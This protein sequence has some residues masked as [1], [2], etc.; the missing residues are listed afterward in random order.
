[1]YNKLNLL[2]KKQNIMQ[3]FLRTLTLL[4]CLAMP[5][6]AQAQNVLSFD[7]EDGN[8]PAGWTNDA[9]YPWEVVS[10]SQGSG[11]AGTYC[12]KSGN[13]GVGSSTSTLSATF[14]FTTAGSIS[15][16][17]G[18]YGE[19]TSTVWDKCIFTIDGVQQFQYG[20]LAAWDTYS[21][22]VS[23]GEHTF[24]WS[25]SKD[26]SVNPTG[27]AFFVDNVVVELSVTCPKPSNLAISDLTAHTATASWTAGGSE[28]SWGVYVN[29]TYMGTVN[30]PSYAIT[31]LDANTDCSFAVTSICG[32]EDASA[33]LSISFHTPCESEVLP[34][35]EAFDANLSSNI[36][37]GYASGITAADVF[38]GTPLTIN[39]GGPSSGW[40]YQSA[41]SNG[42]PA[43]HYRVNIYG[44]SC[45][46]WMVTPNIDLTSATSA[47]LTFDAA[48]TVY[49]SGSSAPA[50]GF[51]NNS[52]QAFMVLISTDGG[53]TWLESNATKWQ[54]EGGNY[55]LASLASSDYI[56][57]TVNLNQ[58]LGQN[59]RIAFYAQS[60]TS[61]GDNNLHIDNI[62]IDVIPTCLKVTNL[63]V[64]NV[65]NNTVTLTWTDAINTGATY[66]VYNGE[67]LVANGIAATT[68]TVTGLT[69]NTPYTF[70][71]VANCA[72]DD[73][74]RPVSVST[75][76]EC[77]PFIT[78]PYSNDLEGEPYYSVVSYAEAFPNC[79][80]RFND[81]STASNGYYPRLLSSSS[82]S[83]SGSVYMQLYST[84]TA[85]YAN[86]QMA[87]LPAVD[88]TVYPMNNNMV[89]F[90]ARSSNSTARTVIVGT[91]SDPTDL[92]TFT[93]V[94][95]VT[96]PGS[97]YEFFRVKLTSSPANN[98]YVAI[99]FDRNGSAT[100]YVDDIALEE[101]PS[102][103]VVENLNVTGVTN[104]SIS[105]S[106]SANAE[107]TGDVTYIVM[108]GE[109]VVAS[110]L[111]TTEYTVTGLAGSTEY[112]LSVLSSC[113]A[114]DNA[115]P[116]SVTVRTLC[117]AQSLPY[118][119]TFE[120]DDETIVCYT[121]SG[122]NMWSV[123]TGD[124]STETGAHSGTYN[125][126]IIHSNNGDATKLIS[127][128]LDLTSVESAM[129]KFWHI[130]RAW[131][132]DQ[133]ELRVYYRTNADADWTLIP[134]AE[135]TEEVA[136]WTEARFVLPNPTATYQI[137]FEMTD[138][139]GYGVAIDD[140]E[141][142]ETP[143]H[144][145]ALSYLTTEDGV[146][147]GSA[148]ADNAN[149]YWGNTV[150]LT[151]TPAT[152][153]RTAAWYAGNLTSVEGETPLAIDEDE[154]EFVITSDTA[155]TVV[156]GYGQFEIKGITANANQ[157]RMGSVAGNS[158]YDNDMYDYA[159][160]ATLTATANTGFQFIEWR[161]E[162]GSV[163]ST[164]N[165]I[166]I[167]AYQPLTLIAH[168]G[169]ATYTV[170]FE[171]EHGTVEGVG[172]YTFGSMAT[173]TAV[174]DEHY[175]FVRWAD[176]E[177][178]P[179][180]TRNI[181]V[182]SDITVL[183]I[184]EPDVYTVTVNGPVQVATYT[185][186]NA[187]G[188]ATN[189][190]EYLTEATVAATNIDDEHYTFVGWS[191]RHQLSERVYFL[192]RT[193]DDVTVMLTFDEND[194]VIL[195]DNYG[196]NGEHVNATT[197]T[198]DEINALLTNGDYSINNLIDPYVYEWDEVVSTVNPY[199][200]AVES[201]IT[202]NPVF[203]A[204]QMTL[205]IATNDADMGTVYFS[206]YGSTSVT[207]DY[208][209]EVWVNAV[210]VGDYSNFT[211]W[212]NGE[213]LVSTDANYLATVDQTMTLTAHFEFAQYAVNTYVEPVEAGTAVASTTNPSFSD[214]VTFTATANPHWV[215][216][217]WTYLYSDIPVSGNATYEE[218]AFEPL[219]LVA[220]FVRDEHTI[221]AEVAD[222]TH[223][224]VAVTNDAMENAS[225]FTHG[226]YATVEFTPGYG[227][228][229]A[230][231]KDQNGTEV[232]YDNP[233]YF[234]VTEDTTLTA[235]VSPL[236]YSVTVLVADIAG[237][238]YG[239][240][241][242]ASP[243][244][245]Y[246]TEI[247]SQLSNS[248]NYGYVFDKWT[249][250]NGDEIEL[251]MVLTQDTVIYANFKKDQFTVSGA[252]AADYRMM[253]RAT[254]TATVD[255]LETV[256]ITAV[257]NN[258][259]HFVKW[260]D[261]DGND[262][263]D[264]LGNLVAAN[265]TY[266]EPTTTDEYDIFS[267]NGDELTVLAS[268]NIT[269]YPVFD[270]EM[271][272]VSVA[273]NDDNMGNVSINGQFVASMDLAYSQTVTLNAAA[274]P[275]YH[276]VE[277]DDETAGTT[278]PYSFILTEPV[279]YEAT[280][281]IDRHTV[282][283]DITDADQIEDIT[284]DGEYDWDEEVTVSITPA[285]GWDFVE[286]Q[287][288]DGNS[289]STA[290][291]YVFNIDEDIVLTPVFSAQP[292]T[293][294]VAVNNDAMGTATVNNAASVVE[295]YA[296]SVTL[297]AT[298]N[299][300]YDFVNWTNNVNTDVLTDATV[301]VTVEGDITYTANFIE[302]QYTMTALVNDEVMGG[303]GI[304]ILDPNAQPVDAEMTAADGTD[305]NSYVPVYGTWADAYLRSQ[306]VYPASDLAN[307]AGAT[308]NSLTY[309]LSSSATA[310]WTGNFKVRLA[311]V[312]GTTIS[313]FQDMSA[314][315][316]A[317][318]GLLDATGS[319]MVINFTTPYVYNGGNLLIEIVED[320][321]GN[322]KS[323]SF[324]GTTVS[325]ASV[326]GY[327]S[328]SVASISASQRNFIP[329]TTFGYSIVPGPTVN[330]F[331]DET[332]VQAAYGTQV[333][334][335]AEAN[336]G[337]HFVDWTNAA[338]EHFTNNPQL[339]DVER[340]STLTANFAKNTYTIAVATQ[341][342]HGATGSVAI[343]GTTEDNIT[344]EY[345]DEVTLT[346][347]VAE[348]YRLLR[349]EDQ[350][351]T[352]LGN[353]NPLTISATTDSTITAV[354]DYE[355]YT[356][357]ANTEDINMGGVYV[358]D[359]NGASTP[360][361]INVDFEDGALP[362]GWTNDG[363]AAWTVGV[364]DY[365]ASTGTHTGSYNA[366]I[367]HTSSGNATKLVSPAMRFADYSNVTLTFWYINRSW[368]GDIDGLKVY[369]RTSSTGTW[370]VIQSNTSAHA[371]WTES[372]VSLPNLTND[373]QIAFEMYDDYGYGVGLDD[374]EFST[375]DVPGAVPSL[376]NSSA[377]VAFSTSVA[378]TATPNEHY[379]FVGWMGA[380]V[381]TVTALGTDANP[382][383]FVAG[384]STLTALFDGDQMPMTYQVN[385]AVRGTVE[386]P[387]TAEYNTEVEISAIA[388]HGYEFTGW[389]DDATA[390]ATRTVTVA[391]T[392][393]E[394]TYKA[395][396][397]YATYPLDVTVENG[398]VSVTNDMADADDVI[399][400]D[401]THIYGY[402]Y[403]GMEVELTFTANEH[404]HFVVNNN[405][406]T[407]YTQTVSFLEAPAA[408]EAIAVIDQHNVTLA[409]N[410][411]A[412]GTIEGATSGV[413][414]YGTELTFTATPA[415]HQHFV[416]WSDNV[417]DAER[418]IIVESDITLTANFEA[419]Q[420]EVIAEAD[421]AQGTAEVAGASYGTCNITVQAVDYYGDGW[422]GNTIN[423]VQNGVVVDSYSMPNQGVINDAV[424]TT[425]VA[426]V[427]GG[428]PL[429]IE[430]VSGGSMSYP[431]EIEFT[432]LDGS[433]N[434][435]Y[436]IADATDLTTGAVL[437]EL[438]NACPDNVPTVLPGT[439]VT[440]TATANPGYEFANWT[441]AGVEVSTENPYSMTINANTTLTANFTFNGFAV[442]VASNNDVMGSAYINDDAEQTSYIAAYEE[443]VT[444]NAVPEY[445][446][447]FINWTVAGTEVST[448]NPATVQ[449]TDA[450]NYVANF[451]FHNYTLTVVSD[452]D[453]RGTATGSD[454]YPYGTQVEISA[455]ANDGYVFLQW[456]DGVT[457]NP[458]T[459]TVDGDVTY[460][461]SFRTDA[462]YTVTVNAVNGVVNGQ[463]GT[464]LENDNVT[465]T[466]T[467]A[468]GYR[469]VNW[470][471]LDGT[472]LSTENPYSF[473]INS[474]VEL[475]ANFDALP[476]VVTL[477]A[478]ATMGTVTGAGEY[479]FG[480]QVEISA[481]ANDGYV[482]T[483]WSDDVTTNPR[484]IV[485]T[486]DVTL[487]AEF[488]AL[489]PATV[490]IG[491]AAINGSV[492]GAGSY[493]VGSTVTL[494]ATPA[495]ACYEFAGWTLD[496]QTV[497][498]NTTLTFTAEVNA[499]Y[500]ATFNALELSGEETV[501]ACVTYTWNGNTYT[502]SGDYTAQLTTLAGCDSTATL[503]LTINTPIDETYNAQSCT[504]YTWN[505]NNQ[506]Y[507]TSGT[508]TAAITD[509][510][511]CSATATLN[512]VIND[513]LTETVE[514][515]ACGS[516]TWNGN[517][518]TESGVY[519]YTTTGSNS[520][521]SVVTLN[522]TINE[523][524]QPTEV[525]EIACGSYEFNGEYYTQSGDYVLN[526]IA[527]NGCD[528][529]V[530]LHLTINQATASTVTVETCDSYTWHENTYTSS[531]SYI[532][533]T[534]GSNGCDSTV[535][536][537]L[538]INT[539]VSQVIETTAVGSYEWNGTVYTES[540][541][542]TFNG[543]TV[544]GCDSTVTLVLTIQAQTYNVTVNVNDATMGNVNPA[545]TITV[546][547]GETFSATAEANDGFRFIGWSNGET[548]T[549]VTITV[550]SDTTL[551]ANFEAIMYT[552]NA[553]ANDETM[554]YVT[555]SGEYR[556]G[557]TVVLEAVA[558]NGYE[559][560]RWSDGTTEAH[561]EFTAT[562]DV[563]ITAI[564]QASVGIEDVDNNDVTIY[565][566]DNKIIV[567]GAE[568]Q[569]IYVYDVNGRCVRTQAN[570]A[571]TVEFTMNTTGVFLVKAGNAPAKR[572]VVV[573]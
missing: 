231:W 364:G 275:H 360:L 205:T 416:N 335:A 455:V 124:Y 46:Y 88:A 279:S 65:T 89:S 494:T 401:A 316:V 555:G 452:D 24:T 217:H 454:V 36:C 14:T 95:T 159:T 433:D 243:S 234:E 244:Y 426:T 194:D 307:M 514:A 61:G 512:L 381:D 54:N 341:F 519:T 545:G 241:D 369:Y 79:W 321:K 227:Y 283:F 268:D 200:F 90:W 543:T 257:P 73:A 392:D 56:E 27:D 180:D 289:L 225:T 185:V 448:E 520:C 223:G 123:G 449:I 339:I 136:E 105:L 116:V 39:A 560:V 255:Y 72:A 506:T 533:E 102:C 128:M 522:L 297:V 444:L 475:N 375:T 25:Y 372:S 104:N 507:T 320:V 371:S 553:T 304:G 344:V 323:A 242:V 411:P 229:F 232:S 168:F 511:N 41:A 196:E 525:S 434:V 348:P 10:S 418:T 221:V 338:D 524:A 504:E 464:F 118:A 163:Y 322:Y 478:D 386:G 66:S 447:D 340:D 214:M 240:A 8:V 99:R 414:D 402:Y 476:Y 309:Y 55:T 564:F 548:S 350:N 216:S 536:L 562:A 64:S 540:G 120:A 437:A 264:E 186:T 60:T 563:T 181:R 28:T 429:S 537:A 412:L 282:T 407:S 458:R 201:N 419:N 521:D 559:F 395:N 129:L 176:D 306:V 470:T 30:T 362:T 518:Y 146:T 308:I 508:Y 4:A 167:E 569:T 31:G 137:A 441:N 389:D 436:T 477:V 9:T 97:T 382:T 349:W 479:D 107:N 151:S 483:Q 294:N 387:A 515:S 193:L 396:F 432:I 156:Y 482:F 154:F 69:A 153:M 473:V 91:M 51:E 52:T 558:N 430:W 573:R 374:I 83:H 74:S 535:T 327:S 325:G 532:F 467:P 461:A 326:Q 406:V 329:K 178:L 13:A 422:T 466:A 376:A 80:T 21:F 546:E 492:E 249:N 94:E 256:T 286:W 528:S 403:Y 318:D 111:T 236:P 98:A 219:N 254:G 187:A 165:P 554:G 40:A 67:E 561:Y 331:V 443:E 147:M 343:T 68:Y 84:T 237:F 108:N 32:A 287:D 567:N 42:L 439:V 174:P 1:M 141:I 568:N 230:A 150:T 377:D 303:V 383:I 370:N 22:D 498:T 218:M 361:P 189:A 503:H 226:D 212:Y 26:G 12:I 157:A 29:G 280:F 33:P 490:Y 134:G 497:S 480:T 184:F 440:F 162:D 290:V 203:D 87:V 493:V 296:E 63:A 127:P 491:A 122:N 459:I 400:T 552:I 295:D 271:Y 333:S 530:T 408:I 86:T 37:W 499:T 353:T 342:N 385:N 277:W 138:G 391:G 565:S 431:D 527:Q 106:W 313:S 538:T 457:T 115:L 373:Y 463:N 148:V 421:A 549:T 265:N 319:T 50:S 171:G 355:V 70:S 531:G 247:N 496:G 204:E 263:T 96:I 172:P 330:N 368:G 117:D 253:G 2:T 35:A 317:Y 428:E 270:Y 509:V 47:Q 110:G 274:K 485:V 267:A 125:A 334:Y 571:E 81:A 517:T 3:K 324:Y 170:A 224:T 210:P 366:K 206:D 208:L 420:Y 215:F 363:P 155:F 166:Q 135:Y 301:E 38:N 399:F 446:Y 404:Y 142:A 300:G 469:F 160:T 109:Q 192:T 516:Y 266:V 43:G 298:P 398:T 489:P 450:V 281:A 278:N 394:N 58:Y 345:L 474:N 131:S 302:H 207:V 284:G 550:E 336:Y 239:T 121:V 149:P 191:I 397:G 119:T 211:G 337:Y 158:P 245:P 484:T 500:M 213:D 113:G 49:T 276:F 557:A 314:A 378:V 556:A 390:A 164:E 112:T 209:T 544:A 393:A 365:S 75:R 356:L 5:W 472:E 352:S 114:N 23:A 354:F 445:G 152:N 358:N 409:V 57:Q 367:T 190:F 384:D 541:E 427:N 293:V 551:T 195:F 495:T 76:T 488:E 272:T 273:S 78:L 7:F 471:S 510:N 505:V 388:A 332:S 542:Y 139:Y 260:V 486:G 20:A 539:S 100:V 235:A 311:E 456:N 305:N 425:Y 526:L 357:T 501:E 250:A 415:E 465:L 572:V 101:I 570:A 299:Y 220:H 251:P 197:M 410:D 6:V 202:L 413:Y 34:F 248:P 523:A 177:S 130:Q 379:H 161:N 238:E 315:D 438:T 285:F 173:L 288:A 462:E 502:A 132:G 291:D 261:A 175:H 48:F 547:A 183:P 380:N 347:T 44:T 346:A 312:D 259:Y 133:D 228:E 529:T 188:E 417:E 359:P 18:I 59:I 85:S 269:V 481:T 222:A 71:V 487:T 292:F 252:V 11:H 534:V 435:L 140:I 233:F 144:T 103:W 77:D 169:I 45:K 145:I 93:E 82:S 17:G 468:T 19:G 182:V 199:T 92:S 453:E 246:L 179:G 262:I 15:F 143:H 405:N 424:N 16:L 126:R 460:T 258:G 451:N 351:G 513:V 442:S 198:L 328:S 62:L 423:F 310:A 53:Q 566:V